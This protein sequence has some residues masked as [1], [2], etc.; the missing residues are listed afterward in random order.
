MIVTYLPGETGSRLRYRY[1]KKRLRYLGKN[2]LIDEGVYFYN[3]EYIYI[4]DNAW[5]DKNVVIMAGPFHSKREK[6]TLQNKSY[7]GE[8][9]VVFIGK[10]VHIGTGGIL[11]GI[12]AGIYISDNCSMSAYCKLYALTHHYKS[13]KNPEK[14]IST[15]SRAPVESQSLIDGAIYLGPNVGLALN[16]ALLPGVALPGNNFVHINS[17]VYMGRYPK[18]IRLQGDPAKK[19][20]Y[21]TGSAEV[22][23]EK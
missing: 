17:V 22:R 18:D 11:S 6:R 9:G 15:S 20:G 19:V 14:L 5:I 23:N 21:R 7:P 8:P 3:S 4:D 1:W 2:V 12:S 10:N 16:C 13:F